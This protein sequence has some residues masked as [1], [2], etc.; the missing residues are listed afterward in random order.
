MKN[1]EDVDDLYKVLSETLNNAYD[2]GYDNAMKE[3]KQKDFWDK[4]H[5]EGLKDAWKLARDL[6]KYCNRGFSFVFRDDKR[7]KKAVDIILN[8]PVEDV[9][10][11][12][13]KNF[14]TENAPD[15][16]DIPT[17]EMTEEQ[18]RQ[19]VKELRKALSE[20]V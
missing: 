4:G 2:R 8:I 7:Y 17:D 1:Y 20:R 3:A 5:D 6:I 19:A 10:E 15:W 13:K 18:L 11:I 12:I 14:N 9:L 16:H